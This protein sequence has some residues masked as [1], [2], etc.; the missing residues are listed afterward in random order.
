LFQRLAVR[1]SLAPLEQLRR[2]LPRLAQGDIPQ[3]PADALDEVRPLVMEVNRLLTLLDQRQRWI[4]P[5][6]GRRKRFG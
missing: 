5:A 4:T 6:I 2:E 3:L 1:R